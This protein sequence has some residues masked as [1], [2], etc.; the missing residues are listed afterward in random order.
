MIRLFTKGMTGK[1]KHRMRKARVILRVTEPQ[2][3]HFLASWRKKAHFCHANALA[4]L[5]FLTVEW[6]GLRGIMLD[7]W[8]EEK[9]SAQMAVAEIITKTRARCEIYPKSD[10]PNL[11]CCILIFDFFREIVGVVRLGVQ[12]VQTVSGGAPAGMVQS[13]W[14]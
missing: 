2:V 5:W 7:S 1:A 6:Q 3:I 4:Q 12:Y 9:L 13:W 14:G 10:T 8:S 11:G